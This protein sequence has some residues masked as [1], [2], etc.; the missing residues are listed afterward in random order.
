MKRFGEKLHTLRIHHGL[1]LSELA[2]QL[3][4]QSH[5]YINEIEAGRKTPTTALV[6]KVA[7]L[8]G[9]STDALL[10][11]KIEVDTATSTLNTFE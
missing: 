3:G 10:R 1:T 9:V 7:D 5:S 4:Y 2:Q 8:F 11:D 6:I